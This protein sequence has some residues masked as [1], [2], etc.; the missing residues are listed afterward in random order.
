[1]IYAHDIPSAGSSRFARR[2]C[3]ELLCTNMLSEMAN[4]GPSTPTCVDI[5]TCKKIRVN[6]L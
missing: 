2:P 4:S 6:I 5:T 1:M 3:L